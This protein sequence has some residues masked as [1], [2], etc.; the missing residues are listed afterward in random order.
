MKYNYQIEH[1]AGKKIAT[2]D[3]LSRAP[4]RYTVPEKE[5]VLGEETEAYINFII[6]SLPVTEKRLE[7]IKLHLEQDEVLR[8]VMEYCK[9]GWPRQ[10]PD[11]VKSYQQYA[12]YLTIEE[13]LLLMQDRIVI[14]ATMRLEMLEKIHAGHQ[15]ITKCRERAKQSVWWPGLSKTLEETVK[16]CILCAKTSSQRAE[17]M[18]P[19]ILPDR[20]WQKVG[21]D[22]FH[23]KKNTFV[24]V[25]DYYSRYIEIAKLQ[26]ITTSTVIIERLKSIFARHGIPEVVV[27]DNGPQYSSS[28][29]LHFSKVYGFTHLTSSPTYAQ[30]NGEAERAVETIK[31]L[32]EKAKDPYI[33]LLSYRTTP[34]QNGYSPSQLSMGRHLRNNLPMLPRN[35]QPS[36][37]NQEA[38]Q[39]KEETY[40]GKMKV[41][42]DRRHGVRPLQHLHKDDQ[43]IID[44][45][46]EGTVKGPTNEP[47]SYIVETPNGEMRRNR[48]QLVKVERQEQQP[49]PSPAKDAKSPQP[50][51]S[52]PPPPVRRS[53][54]QPKPVKRLDM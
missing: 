40:R 33:A 18:I 34:L 41:N 48:R 6:D 5:Q 46:T 45:K 54:R 17:P 32:L 29:F 53:Q 11:P 21:T 47:R 31:E 36:W 26:G 27:S 44:G 28:E 30:S 19:S 39:K 37:P 16:T 1:I 13:G 38:V 22:L 20:P 24:L 43:V 4:M 7:E 12:P 50:A 10:V 3:T 14:P 51:A 9:S 52:S 49:S 23:H 2:A 35:L 25:V 8:K 42:Y 15:G